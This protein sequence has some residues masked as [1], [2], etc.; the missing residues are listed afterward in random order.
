MYNNA[1]LVA[2]SIMVLSASDN[3]IARIKECTKRDAVSSE[4]NQQD[5]IA[6]K[7]YWDCLSE[8]FALEEGD[9]GVDGRVKRDSD[10]AAW[11]TILP[12]ADSSAAR[13]SCLLTPDSSDGIWA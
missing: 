8:T 5:V 3:Y 4:S 13:E 1:G 7:T 2:E 10:V 9:G 6:D 12:V 11:F